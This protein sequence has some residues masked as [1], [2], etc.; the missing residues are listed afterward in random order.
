MR[1]NRCRSQP[2]PEEEDLVSMVDHRRSRDIRYDVSAEICGSQSDGTIEGRR[3]KVRVEQSTN[4]LC[5]TCRPSRGSDID[6]QTTRV[7]DKKWS[8]W[9]LN[10]RGCQ[11][12]KFLSIGHSPRYHRPSRARI[13]SSRSRTFGLPRYGHEQRLCKFS[14]TCKLQTCFEDHIDAP[15]TLSTQS[16]M[17]PRIGLDLGSMQVEEPSE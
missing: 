13:P 11:V 17:L 15:L 2:V 7:R 4:K 12:P 3:S 16:H 5:E 8:G 6:Q 10:Q 9:H 14:S 1:P